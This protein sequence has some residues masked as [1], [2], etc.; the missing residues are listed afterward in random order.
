MKK[1]KNLKKIKKIEKNVKI[2]IITIDVFIGHSN[3]SNPNVKHS[4]QLD[5]TVTCVGSALSI[6]LTTVHPPLTVIILRVQ[7][8][9][10]VRALHSLASLP[11]QLLQL[12]RGRA[13]QVATVRVPHVNEHG[14]VRQVLQEEPLLAVLERGRIDAV[15]DH[16]AGLGRGRRLR[17]EDEGRALRV[18]GEVVE[19]L[20]EGEG[21]RGELGKAV[22]LEGEKEALRLRLRA[23]AADGV[24]S[25]REGEELDADLVIPENHRNVKLVSIC[26]MSVRKIA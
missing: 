18:E 26:K 23:S 7:N 12:Q 16:V 24:E 8:I 6:H 25:A 10:L 21:R 13:D 5:M 9:Q 20:V 11:Q 17:L 19:G 15:A 2:E 22:E 3:V 4:S 1:L 14:V